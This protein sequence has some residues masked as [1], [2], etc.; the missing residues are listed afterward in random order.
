MRHGI[1][2]TLD[3]DPTTDRGAIRRAYAAR[4]K[5]MDVDADPDAFEALRDARDAALARAADPVAAVEV[6]P[7]M[8]DDPPPPEPEA[9]P[10]ADPLVEAMNA[11][12]H[13]LEA[14]LFPGHD[15]APTPQE[16][17][18]ID[19]HGRAL[20]ADPRLETLDFAASAERWFAE[21]LAA[22][23]PRSDPLLEPAAAAF[24]WIGRRNDYA[25]SADAHAIVERIGATR[26]TVLLSDPKHRWH[27]AWIELTREDDG[28]RK[29]MLSATDV[30]DLLTTIRQRYPDVEGWMNPDRV[31]QWSKW[32]GN[33]PR[34]RMRAWFAL[35]LLLIALRIG[36]SWWSPADPGK[37]DADWFAVA[38]H[39]TMQTK[40]GEP[41]P[42]TLPP[43]CVPPKDR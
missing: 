20:L 15:A 34:I 32:S 35:A 11:H 9:A 10:E 27:K 26:F 17:A 38:M 16:L 4:L 12:F 39:L 1:W 6:E 40:R 18:E 14:L 24:G 43:E 3:C 42:K 8:A 5:A 41:L 13:A 22:S 28:R 7:A 29:W 33:G 23:I 2:A 30:R 25:L 36:M 31:A 21:T 37:L 19:H